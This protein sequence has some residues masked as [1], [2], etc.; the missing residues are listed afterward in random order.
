MRWRRDGA[1]C[2]SSTMTARIR[3]RRRW[4]GPGSRSRRSSIRGPSRARRRAVWPDGIPLYSGH[5]VIGTAGRSALR[6]VWVRPAD[7]SGAMAGAAGVGRARSRSTAICWP[8]RAA[9]TRM[10]SFSR[11]RSGRLRFD[12]RLAALVPGESDGGGRLRRGG[13]RQFSAFRLPRRRG[14]GRGAGR[15]VVRFRPSRSEA[16]SLRSPSA[17]GAE[18]GRRRAADPTR[19]V[20]RARG[21]APLSICTTT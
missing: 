4:R 11:R 5:A 19:A 3:W 21:G 15:R 18:S 7:A 13:E 12:P 9:G 2:C 1:R 16:G 17:D 8:Y 14:N 20:R 10:C 6:R